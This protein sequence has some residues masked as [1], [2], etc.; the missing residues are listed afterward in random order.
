M[1]TPGLTF[2][3]GL[4]KVRKKCI[5]NNI[6][7]SFKIYSCLI[8]P[9][10]AT[11][12]TTKFLKLTLNFCS[13]EIHQNFASSSEVKLDLKNAQ[14]HQKNHCLKASNFMKNCLIQVILTY[15]VFVAKIFIWCKVFLYNLNIWGIIRPV[16]TVDWVISITS[17]YHLE[18]SLC[19]YF[20]CHCKFNS[21]T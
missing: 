4:A 9:Q 20:H 5:K 15:I 8:F 16:E 17:H 13:M 21:S 10:V 12:K 2:G 1:H 19:G 11:E 3:V 14:N 18:I 6:S 7:L